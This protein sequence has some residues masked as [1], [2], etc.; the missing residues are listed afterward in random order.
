MTPRLSER[1]RLLAAVRGQPVDYVPCAPF[2]NPL[3]PEQRLGR[4]WQ[5]PFGPSEKEMAE[6]CVN[7]LGVGPPVALPIGDY[8]AN[9]FMS[10]YYRPHPEVTWRAWV[11]DGQIHKVYRTPAGEIRA[12]VRYDEKWPHGLDV[13]FWSD[14]TIGHF[15]RPWLETEQ[16]LEC[17]RY[18]LRPLDDKDELDR[19][20]FECAEMKAV[21]DR[22]GLATI[23]HVGMGLTG[24]MQ[25][26]GAERICMMTL[27]QPDLVKA[28][29]GLDHQ[30]NMRH[31]EIACE[32][33]ADVIRRNGFYE[34][35]DFY[36]PR[37]LDEFLG[38]FLREE[39]AAV[40]AAGKPIGYTVNTGVMPMLDYLAS[41]DFD[42]LLHLDMAVEG[43]D[44][45]KI[46][47]AMAGRKSFW[48]GPS[49]VHHMTGDDPELPR[50]ALRRVFDV[51]G[52]QGLIVTPSPSVH[53]IMPWDNFLAMV[54]EW[55]KLR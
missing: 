14:F 30:R 49:S 44:L 41:L 24:A 46:R 33:G 31:M 20:R 8:Q 37:M 11:E 51:F 17:L 26:C 6:Y 21:A 13:P 53:S 29:L 2:F 18:V 28:Y 54:D 1:E 23:A 22:L 39:I 7:V 16:D 10:L 27:E 52:K 40:H 32:L 45:A 25:L 19:V 34:T 55:K 50:R 48:M 42:C 12:S 3:T 43:V 35:C 38:P 47:D 9:F 4:R 15:T 5:F 36:S